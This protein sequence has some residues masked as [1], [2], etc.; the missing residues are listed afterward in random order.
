MTIQTQVNTFVVLY[1]LPRGSCLKRLGGGGRWPYQ[2][3]S[4]NR[5]GDLVQFRDFIKKSESKTESRD[6]KICKFFRIL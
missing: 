6:F 4:Q 1:T 3:C 2:W 5:D